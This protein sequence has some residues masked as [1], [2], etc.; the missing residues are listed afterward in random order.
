MTDQPHDDAELPPGERSLADRLEAD[1]PVPAAGFRGALRRSLD[2][3]DPGYG[4]RPAHLRL[5]VSAYLGACLV[6]LAAAALDA[7][8]TL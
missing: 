2:A 4:P 5:I 3:Q 6:L 7:T 8:G 1:R